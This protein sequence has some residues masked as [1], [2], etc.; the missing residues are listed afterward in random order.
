[1]PT[2]NTPT[3]AM[4]RPS[5][6][7]PNNVPLLTTVFL[8]NEQILALRLLR[9]PRVLDDQAEQRERFFLIVHFFARENIQL[10]R[11]A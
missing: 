6:Q 1:M 5:G 3:K 8:F 11:L 4:D 9:S 10:G 7:S 2:R